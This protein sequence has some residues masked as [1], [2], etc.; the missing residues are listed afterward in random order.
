MVRRV[1][2]LAVWLALGSTIWMAARY[3]EAHQ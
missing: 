2:G 3:L 1:L